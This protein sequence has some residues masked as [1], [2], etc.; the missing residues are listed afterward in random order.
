M[1]D[2]ILELVYESTKAP[3]YDYLLIENVDNFNWERFWDVFIICKQSLY[4][5]YESFEK[6]DSNANTD[7]YEVIA[8]NG[9]SFELSVSFYDKQHVYKDLLSTLF[10]NFEDRRILAGLQK[11]VDETEHPIITINFKDSQD[12]I[13]T[14]NKLGNYAY[15]VI[16]SIKDA[17]VTSLHERNERFP[18]I[19]YFHILKSE[20]RKLNFFVKMIEGI[21][22]RFKNYYVD[23]NSNQQFNLAY[24]YV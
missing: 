11:A 21:F 1:S 14:T 16:Q 10:T 22:P 8:T 23:E 24:F 5:L 7:L 2:R 6:V 18:D 17:I 19:L 4:P 12:E 13:K 9:M 20:Q 3:D 15:S